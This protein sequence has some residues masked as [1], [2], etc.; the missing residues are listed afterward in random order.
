[1]AT[2][3]RTRPS[4]LPAPAP[5][6]SP[7]VYRLN[8]DE[9]TRLSKSGILD[10]DRVELLDGYL[11]KKMGKNPP[12][13]WSVDTILRLLSAML[14]QGWY[15]RKEDPIRIPNFDEPEPDIAIVR[16]SRETY[17]T[18]H[19]QPKDIALLV[20]VSESTLARDR[21]EKR[22]A[23][24]RGRIPIYWIVNLVDRQVEVYTR[25][26]RRGYRSSRIFQAG[27][28]VPVVI[29]ATEVGRIGVNDVLPK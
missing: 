11:V 21:G 29:S 19:P 14:P 2:I 27:Q 28:V 1:M 23:Y 20:E 8:V 5:L 12:H 25:P 13:V 22:A 7:E 3:T 24:A 4:P 10:D 6:A 15:L 18:N 9:Y 26:G 17:S 16:G